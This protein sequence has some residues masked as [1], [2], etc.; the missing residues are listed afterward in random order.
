M[1]VTICDVNGF[2]PWRDGQEKIA[3]SCRE[4]LQDGRFQI[5]QKVL[6]SFQDLVYITK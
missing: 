4:S 5:R 2:Q 3:Y 6:M 1:I